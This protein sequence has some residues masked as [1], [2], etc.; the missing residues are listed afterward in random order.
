ME[1]IIKVTPSELNISLLEKIKSIIGDNDNVDVTISLNE[2]EPLYV[3]TLNKS[4]YQAEEND[5]IQSFTMEEF[6][7]YSPPKQ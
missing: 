5:D 3:E 6:M 7:N 2:Y 1:T 4:I